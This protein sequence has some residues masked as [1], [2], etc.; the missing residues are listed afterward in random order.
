LIEP[1]D[2]VAAGALRGRRYSLVGCSFAMHLAAESL[3]PQLCLELAQ[4]APHLLILTPHKRPTLR[5]AFGWDLTDEFVH[6]RV[7]TRLY[8][9]RL[10]T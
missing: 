1:V 5:P 4:A 8:A 2:E 3:L 10:A 9:S 7:R 6:E